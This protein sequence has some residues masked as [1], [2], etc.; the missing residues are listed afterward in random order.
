M[1][2]RIDILRD[3]EK[4]TGIKCLYKGIFDNELLTRLKSL[5]KLNIIILIL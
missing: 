1:T 4:V 3:L 2:R 5:T